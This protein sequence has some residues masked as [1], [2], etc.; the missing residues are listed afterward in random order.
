MVV[1]RHSDGVPATALSR[2]EHGVCCSAAKEDEYFGT[3]STC[4]K[5][6]T[7]GLRKQE[8]GDGSSTFSLDPVKL[9]AL[10]I[11]HLGS[12]SLAVKLR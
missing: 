12:N 5:D 8:T 7:P 1:W 4:S 3:Q 2:F 10:R 11:E 6:L 9:S